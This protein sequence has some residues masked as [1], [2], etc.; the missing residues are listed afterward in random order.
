[1]SFTICACEVEEWHH[2][3]LEDYCDFSEKIT[4][5]NQEERC[6]HTKGRWYY[7]PDGL[8]P[9]GDRVIYFGTWGNDNAP[10]SSSYT[11]AEV[12][13]TE[14]DDE[15]AK[16]EKDMAELK[17][18]PE[19][20]LEDDLDEEYPNFDEM[21]IEGL[22]DHLELLDTNWAEITETNP[23]DCSMPT[24]SEVETVREY[25]KDNWY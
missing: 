7:I 1:M 18:Y 24:D 11:Y 21:S 5:Y 19:W 3:E 16:F 12:Y 9:N 6:D 20:V 2:Y 25:L 17:A 13:D 15:K 4:E 10:G 14:D 23:E 22:K 8:L